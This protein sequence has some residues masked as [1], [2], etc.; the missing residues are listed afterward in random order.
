MIFIRQ[1]QIFN[2]P[3]AYEQAVAEALP[4]RMGTPYH[5]KTPEEFILA[6]PDQSGLIDSSP[7]LRAQERDEHGRF[8]ASTDIPEGR[9]NRAY[10]WAD[11]KLKIQEKAKAQDLYNPDTGNY[12]DPNT[13]L[14]I[15][16]EFHYGHTTGNESWRSR[17][18]ATKKGMSHSE[19]NKAQQNLEYWKVEDPKINMSHNYE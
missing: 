1:I 14:E 7:Y 5:G 9:L 17:D 8:K 16:G 19:Y 4:T 3:K 18:E 2:Q 15:E 12:I 11:T 10:P 6:T 13:G